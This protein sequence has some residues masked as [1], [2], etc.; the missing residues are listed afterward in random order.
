[1]FV[2]VWARAPVVTA[3]FG[4]AFLNVCVRFSVLTA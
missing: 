2:Q 4:V 3:S 1:V